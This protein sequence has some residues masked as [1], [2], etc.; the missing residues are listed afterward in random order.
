MITSIYPVLMS[1]D[2]A[3]TAAF[4]RH[5]FAMEAV[6][7]AGWY[8]SLRSGA[9]ELAVVDSAH[10]TIPA[11]FRTSAAGILVNIEVDDVDSEY[12][13]LVTRGGALVALDLRS[14]TFGQRHVI[15]VAPGNVLVD[16]I[17]PIPVTAVG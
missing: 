11:G 6:F 16:V 5:A 14:E 2:V 4:F 9:F 12:E 8:V 15:L 17:Q 3:E 13:R 7:E 10:E 1:T